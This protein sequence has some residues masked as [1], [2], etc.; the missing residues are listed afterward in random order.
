MLQDDPSLPAF[1]RKPPNRIVSGKYPHAPSV[2][3]WRQRSTEDVQTEPPG[4]LDLLGRTRIAHHAIAAEE[5]REPTVGDWAADPGG[6]ALRT[7]VSSMLDE[8]D[9]WL[10]NAQPIDD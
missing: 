10:K 7:E 3:S 8:L 9:R 4:N 2:P 6:R 1:T 5:P